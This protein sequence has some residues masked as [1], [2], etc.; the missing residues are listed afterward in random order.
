[1]GS[2]MCIRDS[3]RPTPYNS[4]PSSTTASTP[5]SRALATPS[6]GG[7]ALYPNQGGPQMYRGD[8]AKMAM[9]RSIPSPASTSGSSSSAQN[10][11]G[12]AS[13]S[14]GAYGYTSGSGASSHTARRDSLAP[15]TI[16]EGQVPQTGASRM[17]AAAKRG[18]TGTD[19]V[20]RSR[21][22]SSVNHGT[23]EKEEDAHPLS[24]KSLK[25]R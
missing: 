6:T 3:T 13:N 7:V 25:A 17:A 24:E 14:Y 9:S 23:V 22:G 21:R 8:L 20:V 2:E 18:V 12:G 11:G 1:M 10:G 19:G 4:Q 16:N 15:G 5:S